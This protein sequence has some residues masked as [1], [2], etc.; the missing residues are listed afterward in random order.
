MQAQI[1]I[2]CK[3]KRGKTE[4]KRMYIVLL[5]QWGCVLEIDSDN[6]IISS[7]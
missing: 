3:R 7:Y 5:Y 6:R 4:V 1:E 2:V